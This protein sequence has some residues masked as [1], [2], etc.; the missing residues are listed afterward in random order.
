ME[1]RLPCYL[2]EESTGYFL[3][4]TTQWIAPDRLRVT[5]LGPLDEGREVLCLVWNRRGLKAAHVRA[6]K[7]TVKARSERMERDGALYRLDLRVTFGRINPVGFA[8]TGARGE[9]W[10]SRH[11]RGLGK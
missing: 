9:N 7:H 3:E 6:A 1:F 4:A 10:W 5:A 8:E 2:L 11:W